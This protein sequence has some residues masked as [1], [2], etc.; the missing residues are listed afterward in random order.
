[1]SIAS[2]SRFTVPLANNQSASTQG[3]L[4]PKLAFRFRVTLHLFGISQPVTELTKQVM[5]VT[6]PSCTFADIK[7]DTYNSIIKLAGK[8][9]WQDITLNVRDDMVGMVSMLVGEQMQKQFDFMEQ[10]S[11]SS[12]IDYKFVTLIEMLDGGNGQIISANVLEAWELYGCYIAQ[13]NY[14]EANYA[15]ND[16]VKIAL[17]I[18]Y[19]NAV[20]LPAGVNGAGIGKFVGRTLGVISTG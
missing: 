14:G 7:L 20:Q 1:M 10:A 12:G 8:P 5:D 6:R 4:M 19:D 18:K 2:L 13:V 15:T 16:A 9:E 17:T 3:L 11:A